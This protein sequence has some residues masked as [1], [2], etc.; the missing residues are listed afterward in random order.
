VIG[1]NQRIGVVGR[2]GAGKTSVT[3]ALTK[4]IDLVS[5]DVLVNGKSLK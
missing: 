3:L 2:T 5:G 1:G 4:V